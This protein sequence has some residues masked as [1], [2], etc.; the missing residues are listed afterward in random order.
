M[1]PPTE[2]DG[3]RV[4]PDPYYD[5]I[6]WRMRAFVLENAAWWD[7]KFSGWY[8]QDHRLWLIHSGAKEREALWQSLFL[9]P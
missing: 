2:V 3:W 8:A 7:G 4:V 9:N 1:N 6:Y 5:R